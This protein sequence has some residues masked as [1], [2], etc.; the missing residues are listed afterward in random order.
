MPQTKKQITL[1]KF[2]AKWCYPCQT[3]KPTIAEFK[4]QHPDVIVREIDVDTVKGNAEADT[5]RVRSIP[6]MIMM[7]DDAKVWRLAST[8]GIK[9]LNT[10][11]AKATA[12]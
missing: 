1:I 2:T 8:C 7:A 5:F 6:T 9:A 10:A 12:P 4:K 3:M 11:Y